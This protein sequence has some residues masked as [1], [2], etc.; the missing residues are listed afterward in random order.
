MI[1]NFIKNEN[2]IIFS[3]NIFEYSQILRIPKQQKFFQA[4]D[5]GESNSPESLLL[6]DHSTPEHKNNKIIRGVNRR[7]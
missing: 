3:I 7:N 5:G 1:Y 4:R 2:F 6:E